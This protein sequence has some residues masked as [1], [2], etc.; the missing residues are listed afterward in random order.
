ML[1]RSASFHSHDLLCYNYDNDNDD[2]SFHYKCLILEYT[3]CAKS[4]PVRQSECQVETRE[5]KI[6]DF[7]PRAEDEQ[8]RLDASPVPGIDDSI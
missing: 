5:A 8:F 7:S 6:R 2:E 4:P 3:E 1:F